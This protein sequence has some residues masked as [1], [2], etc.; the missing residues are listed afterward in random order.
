MPFC[1]STH[2]YPDYSR[3]IYLLSHITYAEGK[4]WSVSFVEI[5]DMNESVKIVPTSP[6]IHW[7]IFDLYLTYIDPIYHLAHSHELTT[8]RQHRLTTSVLETCRTIQAVYLQ[9]S[10]TVFGC[11]IVTAKLT[12]GLTSRV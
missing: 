12:D 3:D 9:R 11:P 8:S 2:I 5:I 4:G 6:I 7:P 1:L 10:L